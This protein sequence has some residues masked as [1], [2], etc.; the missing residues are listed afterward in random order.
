MDIESLK[1]FLVLSETKNFTRTAN[2][3]FVAQSTITN[4]ISELEKELGVSLFVRNNRS[5]DLTPEGEHFRIY[6]EKV[7][8]LTDSS[9]TEISSLHKYDNQLRIGAADSIYESHLAD[10][11]LK[12]QQ[13]NPQDSLRMTIGLSTHLLEQLQDDI[14]DVV[15]SYLPL[16]K[17]HYHCALYRQDKLVLVT[18]IKNK[19]FKKGITKEELLTTNYLM[20]NFALKDVGQFI[21]NLF[22]KYH[23]FA[24]EIDDCSKIIPFLLGSNT[25][26]FLPEDMAAPYIKEKK[27]Q[28]IPLI[29]LNTPK[30]NSYIIGNNS[31]K[32]LWEKIFLDKTES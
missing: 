4:R 23:Q 7:V 29:D 19:K 31:K 28:I 21:R 26:T 30:I 3:I 8:E 1:T 2:Q 11:I 20:C 15:F 24:L 22:P 14:L 9:L 32:E 25:Y 5:V 10:T 12:H 27:L 16:T 18:D 6:A 13:T 17:A